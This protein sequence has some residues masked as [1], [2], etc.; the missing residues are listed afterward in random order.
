MVRSGRGEKV[1]SS[2]TK[3]L[4]QSK[5]ILHP[6]MDGTACYQT[7]RRR[8]LERLAD[9]ARGGVEGG[10]LVMVAGRGLSDRYERC[11]EAAAELL[12][13]LLPVQPSLVLANLSA[14]M[15]AV[16]ARLA[17]EQP[18]ETAEEVRL[19]LL[20]LVHAVFGRNCLDQ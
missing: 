15:Q 19:R 11:R 17:G 4:P 8:A 7:V 12:L 1:E 18:A 16:T 13:A 5:M 2:G 3:Y 9:M 6:T 14:T 20:Q 10:E